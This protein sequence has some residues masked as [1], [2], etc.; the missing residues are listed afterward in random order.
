MNQNDIILLE[1]GTSDFERLKEAIA[2][3]EET[4][5]YVRLLIEPSS[6]EELFERGDLIEANTDY[7]WKR[8]R[9]SSVSPDGVGID[10]G[11]NFKHHTTVSRYSVRTD[12]RKDTPACLKVKAYEGEWSPAIE[13]HRPKGGY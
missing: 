5:S 1:A 6:S 3:A 12:K 9:V 4:S 7:G 2:Y 11:P 13:S 8:A 10:Y